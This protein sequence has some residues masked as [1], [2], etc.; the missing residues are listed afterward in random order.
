MKDLVSDGGDLQ[1]LR[2]QATDDGLQMLRVSGAKKVAH[3]L[4]T[5]DEVLRVTPNVG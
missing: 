2:G 1:S 5:I 3:G 4:T